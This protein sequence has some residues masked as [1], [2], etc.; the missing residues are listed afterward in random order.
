MQ[1]VWRLPAPDRRVRSCPHLQAAKR[2]IDR[3]DRM[4]G[5]FRGPARWWYKSG[6]DER[7]DDRPQSDFELV[8]GER[9]LRAIIAEF[10]QAV[11]DDVMI[12]FLFEGKP[13]RRIVEME[14][15]LSAEQLG[16]PVR[17]DGRSMSA[18]HGKLPIMG[19]H[20]L[21][22]RK[23]LENTLVAHRV[24]AGVI[25]RW[26]GHVDALRDEVLGQGVSA[27]D[28]NHELQARRAGADG[29]R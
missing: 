23:I 20:F 11:F 21:R 9:G 15:R 17:Y 4:L 7:Q 1:G 27:D 18:A 3:F 10:T 8:G 6:V 26:L 25:E 19:G 24:D 28:C 22:R 16:G 13:K 12:G 14:Y 2:S 5:S 29:S